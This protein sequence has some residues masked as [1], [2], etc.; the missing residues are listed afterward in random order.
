MTE[1]SQIIQWPY[2]LQLLPRTGSSN[3]SKCAA[4]VGCPL[5]HIYKPLGSLTTA[6]ELF[7]HSSPSVN[8][9]KLCT[10][11]KSGPLRFGDAVG[12]SLCDVAG[13]LMSC[14]TGGL[15]GRVLLEGGAFLPADSSPVRL[16]NHTPRR[17]AKGCGSILQP[18][19]SDVLA[20]SNLL[21]FSRKLLSCCI[22][23]TD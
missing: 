14:Q 4:H 21:I 9:A 18:Q 11:G 1:F 5:W 16:P 22:P 17:H 2:A 23:T 6:A 10:H 20:R 8:T 7:W 15:H 12:M 19:R 3:R 13:P